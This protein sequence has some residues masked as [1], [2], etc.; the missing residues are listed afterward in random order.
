MSTHEMALLLEG[1]PM[2]V[3]RDMQGMQAIAGISGIQGLQSMENAIGL[4]GVDLFG[5]PV[6]D[7]ALGSLP[8]RPAPSRQLERRLDELR[9]RGCCQ[10]IAWSRQGTIA[11]IAKDAMSVDLRFLRCSPD[12][13]DWELSRHSPWAA[14][15]LSPSPPAL[16][17]FSPISLASAGAPFVHLAWSPASSPDLAAIDALGRVTIFSFSICL[18]R[19][20]F[21]RKWDADLVDDLHAVVGCYWLPLA[22]QP[23]KQASSPSCCHSGLVVLLTLAKSST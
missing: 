16:S 3:D 23:N 8:A 4:D 2:N 6:M 21:S 5:D 12:N 7:T 20:Y 1:D 13:G 15:S 14:V 11:A 18:N 22:L 9:T 10:A 17:P 19:P